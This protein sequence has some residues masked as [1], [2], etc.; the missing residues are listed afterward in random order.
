[1]CPSTKNTASRNVADTR[2]TDGLSAHKAGPPSAATSQAIAGV[3]RSTLQ[4]L[5]GAVDKKVYGARVFFAPDSD[6]DFGGGR[7][8]AGPGC[9]CGRHCRDRRPIGGYRFG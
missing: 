2:V 3:L 6:G 9:H 4:E 5:I 7:S 8:A 1:A